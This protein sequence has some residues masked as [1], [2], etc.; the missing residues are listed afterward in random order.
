MQKCMGVNLV[1]HA[2]T[3]ERKKL[4]EAWEQRREQLMV[5]CMHALLLVG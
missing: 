3:K 2:K 1:A 5:Q 4:V